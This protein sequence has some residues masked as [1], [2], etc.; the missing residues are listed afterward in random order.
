M[1][2]ME[3]HMQAQQYWVDRAIKV[4]KAEAGL[5]SWGYEHGGHSGATSCLWRRRPPSYSGNV[6]TMPAE[7][8][9]RSARR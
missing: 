1:R 7:I 9:S 8:R 4:A 2:T 5:G 6:S 3:T